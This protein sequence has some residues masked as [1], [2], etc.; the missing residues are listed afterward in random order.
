MTRRVLSILLAI[1]LMLTTALPG[2]AVEPRASEYI[3]T[4]MAVLN[5]G[6]ESGV[7][8][9]S[10]C[11]MSAKSDITRIGVYKYILYKSDGSYV[12]TVYG[13]V[14]NGL[15][16]TS[17]MSVNTSVSISGTSGESYYAVVTLIVGDANGSDTRTVTTA[18]VVCP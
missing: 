15:L 12:R 11:V 6:T 4:Y 8:R 7:M 17:G 16:R 1:A 3:D 2:L 18:T 14:A 10:Y 5:S 13:T 9:L